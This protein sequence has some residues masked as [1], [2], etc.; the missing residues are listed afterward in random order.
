MDTREVMR[1]Y[2]RWLKAALLGDAVAMLI[3]RSRILIA[4]DAQA[5]S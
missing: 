3:L 1:L 5:K 2:R 4:I